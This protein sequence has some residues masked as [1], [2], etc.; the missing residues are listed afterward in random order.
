[1]NCKHTLSKLAQTN[2][3]TVMWVPG[4]RG[5]QGNDEADQLANTGS[6]HKFYGASILDNRFLLLVLSMTSYYG[7]EVANQEAFKDSTGMSKFR[8]ISIMNALVCLVQ[9]IF[10]Q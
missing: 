3:V 9:L 1:M 2:N 10:H 5:I 8:L 7:Q 6:A 4:H